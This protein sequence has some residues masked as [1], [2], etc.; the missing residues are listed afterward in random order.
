MLSIGNENSY[1]EPMQ[2]LDEPDWWEIPREYVIDISAMVTNLLDVEKRIGIDTCSGRTLSTELSNFLWLDD[3]KAAKNSV[4]ISGAGGGKNIV[5]GIGPLLI[6]VLN[7]NNEPRF[8]FEE[9]AVYIEPQRD[10]PRFRVLGQSRLR[11]KGLALKQCYRG[12]LDALVCGRTKEVIPVNE[13]NGISVL[14]TMEYEIKEEN[15][16]AFMA[17]AKAV[18][19]GD[20]PTALSLKEILQ[21]GTDLSCWAK[22]SASMALKTVLMAT[23]VS[24]MEVSS[25]ILNEA[26]LSDE[27]KAWLWHWRWGHCDFE[28]PVRASKGLDAADVLTNTKLNADCPICDKAHFK[29]KAYKR[30][31]PLEHAE[32]PPFWKVYVDGYGGQGS[33]GG[34]SYEGAIGGFVF[35][36]RSTKTLNNKLYASTEQFPVLL[37]QYLVDVERQH[38]RCR[39]IVVDTH[40]V[41]ISKEAEDVAALFRVKIT[42][43][44]AGTP[45]ENAY[46]ESGVRVIG[47]MSRAF[48]AGAPHLPKK[49]WALAD[50]WSV[51]VRDVRP[52]KA[53]GWKSSFEVRTGRKPPYHEMFLKIFGAPCNFAPID[54]AVHKR[55]ALTEEG[56]FVG[57]QW[58]MALV[59]RKSDMKVISVSRKKLAV[60]EGAYIKEDAKDVLKDALQEI[61]ED[62]TLH[63]VQSVKSLKGHNLNKQMVDPQ[64]E[65]TSVIQQSAIDTGV[66][67]QGEGIHT[68]EHVLVD[69]DKFLSDLE[70]M[71][72]DALKNAEND[73][74]RTK[75]IK[76]IKEVAQAVKNVVLP[77]G[78]LKVGKRTKRSGI[79]AANVLKEKR[80]SKKVMFNE[81]RNETRTFETGASIDEDDAVQVDEDDGK[82]VEEDHDL[83]DRNMEVGKPSKKLIKGDVVSIDTTRF[84]EDSPGSYSLGKPDRL[85]GRVVSRGRKNGTFTI[86]YDIDKEEAVSHWTHLTLEIPK[87]SVETM[88]TILGD[89]SELKSR[90]NDMAEGNWPN[91][92]FEALVRSDWRDWVTAVKKENAGWIVN[93][94]TRVVKYT[95]MKPGARCIPLGELFS[96][97][98]DGRYKFRQIAF[99]NMLRPGK[100]YG[101]TFA[102]TVSADGM[103]WFFALACSTNLQIYGW[104][105]TVGYLQAKLDI[106]VYAYLPS[107]HEYSELSFEELA[108]FREQLLKI[109][110]TEGADGLKRFITEQRKAN[111]KNPNNVLELLKSVYGIPSSGNSFA[112]LMQSTHK[113]KCGLHQTQTDPSIYIKM[114]CKDGPK[115]GDDAGGD[116]HD[117]RNVECVG[118]NG[119]TTMHCTDG[120]VVEFLVIIIW[121]DDVRY[122]GTEKLR[123]Q[124][125]AD[126]KQNLR[127]DFEGASNAFVS[128]D[129]KQDFVN[130]TLEVTQAPYWEKCVEK[131]KDLWPD[132]K[133][134]HRGTPLSPADG[135]FLLE[136]VSDEEWEASKHLDFASILGQIQFPTVYT[137]LEMRFAIS[138]ISRQRSR[139]SRRSYKI[140][141]KALEYGYA[142]RHIGLMFSTG[143]DAHGVNKLYAYADSNFAAPRSQGCRL[144][145]MN[146]CWISMT[147]KRHT[148]TD[149]STCEAEVT[150]M[151][152]CTRDVERLRNLMA[153]V[154]L[155]QQEPT[156]IYQDNMPAIQIMTNR[157]SLPNKSKAMDIRVMSARNKVEDK[158]V[159]P[160]YVSTLEMLADLGTKAL[161]EKQFVF[162]R[163]LANGYALVQARGDVADLPS[164]IISA[165]ELGV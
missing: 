71:K 153:E 158:K 72:A 50:N 105:A 69:V 34:E 137:K 149:T 84:D 65:P 110:E 146:G 141:I 150:E 77:E 162:L 1:S 91:N 111:R 30:N 142:T 147:S 58:P 135:A 2:H 132:G 90:P 139:W 161:D 120:T 82:S 32:D 104:D 163:D 86:R 145:M 73:S 103:R 116:E 62:M 151:F 97:K 24:S 67:N 128:C 88:L 27:E 25:M 96:V 92:F 11:R 154:G 15:K 133:P 59:L 35:Y 114:V 9:Y 101:E 157:G 83:P 51:W 68:P 39:E 63:T 43:I 53:L 49:C 136:P 155:F 19:R 144:T 3:S 81:A 40:S 26:K 94:A 28:G 108:V 20:A 44:S 52:Q 123:L 75:I 17:A 16:K 29:R 125:E 70:K 117:K 115:D 42:P 60:Y 41:N 121:T 31:D 47:E 66:T 18:M 4:C 89:T 143:L 46:A 93:Q 130:K 140:L 54:G 156:I 22:D 109:V 85:F 76:G 23:T 100:D 124:Y 98:R 55:A 10:Q 64:D 14:T 5:G 38:F 7:D 129:F 126:I 134:K 13:C 6:C 102:S 87:V 160:I 152:L 74:L 8:I 113:D 56:W 37:F 131:N 80:A 33:M 107:H 148:T 122:F 165:A 45:Q 106:P 79:D 61:G 138:L 12:N 21:C 112:M 48:L 78:L 164:L 99:G 118:E 127:V 159:I 36:D 57:V 119:T 95:D